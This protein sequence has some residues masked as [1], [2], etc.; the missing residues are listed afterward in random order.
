MATAAEVNTQ[1]TRLG[2][3]RRRRNVGVLPHCPR[4]GWM[5]VRSDKQT[6]SSISNEGP[7]RNVQIVP[8]EGKLIRY[9]I[10]TVRWLSITV[11]DGQ[12]TVDQILNHEHLGILILKHGVVM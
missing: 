6:L 7:W 1:R 8:L 4:S 9:F 2:R 12:C 3:D 5:H 11:T 10:V